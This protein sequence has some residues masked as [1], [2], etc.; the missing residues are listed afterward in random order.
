MTDTYRASNGRFR[1]R[2]G[3]D[4]LEQYG[5]CVMIALLVTSPAWAK[6]FLQFIMEV[7]A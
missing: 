2:T 3:L 1:R 4:I 6:P 5:A 7:T